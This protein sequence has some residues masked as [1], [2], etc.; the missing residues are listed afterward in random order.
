MTK[1]CK[2]MA[3]GIT[4]FTMMG[5]SCFAGLQAVPAYAAVVDGDELVDGLSRDAGYYI[6]P[7]SSKR[8][9][10]YDDISYLSA[11]EKQMA[12]NE[13]Y[14]RHGR[15]FLIPQ[16]Q[17]YF[18]E[19]S[20]YKGTVEA[21]AFDE[22]VLSECE[23]ENIGKLLKV[24]T[25]SSYVLEGSDTRYITDEEVAALTKDE[26]QLA[27]NEIYARHG[28][29]FA[30]KEYRDYF[31][32]KSWYQGTIDPQTFDAQQSSIFNETELANIQKILQW[33]E[34]KRNEGN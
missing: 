16:V 26:M 34:K 7:E 28:R 4:A 14:A 10:S 22:S 6:L 31:N 13:I 2:W 5:G 29:K 3:A 30:M 20:W 27:I 21:S 17:K 11:S 1:I 23:E 9:L 12:I 19:K 33:E 8:E 25:S 32:S 15:K 18:N 24:T